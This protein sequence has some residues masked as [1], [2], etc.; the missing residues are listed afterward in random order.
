MNRILFEA[1]EQGPELL[2]FANFKVG[3]DDVAAIGGGVLPEMATRFD[4]DLPEQP[5][6]AD[7]KGLIGAVGPAKEL[8]KNIEATQKGMHE[9]NSG[10]RRPAVDVARDW[11]ERS[12]LLVPVDRDVFGDTITSPAT[13]EADAD[14][15]LPTRSFGLAVVTGGVLRWM[16]RRGEQLNVCASE[17]GIGKICLVGGTRVLKGSEGPGVLP[18]TTEG[19]YLENFIAP[20]FSKLGY[21]IDVVKP[22]SSKGSDIAGAVADKVAAEQIDPSDVLVVAT[23]GNWPQNG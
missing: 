13:T 17:A 9:R 20:R 8:Q 23:A 12:G 3:E 10:D 5:S 15:E 6:S 11:V 1:P 14:D 4:Y 2:T 22:D 18:K 21:D 16:E 7:L 19:D